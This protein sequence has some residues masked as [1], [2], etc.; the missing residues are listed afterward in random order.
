M[1][2]FF[3]WSEEVT[4]KFLEQTDDGIDLESVEVC[5]QFLQRASMIDEAYDIYLIRTGLSAGK[6]K[7]LVAL[8][9][10]GDE[11]L[12]P[13][14]CAYKAG[15]TRATITGLLDGL[16]RENLVKRQPHYNDRRMLTVRLTEKGKH[17]LMEICPDYLRRTTALFSTLT[18]I[19][20]KLLSSLLAKLS[21][22][23]HL[24]SDP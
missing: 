4:S 24:L 21:K 5:S 2:L 19:E 14:E 23:I 22:G 18:E 20:M 1:P 3:N 7:L 9:A 11:G 10:G 13:S 17:L 15:V 8:L 16:E 12:A 6:F